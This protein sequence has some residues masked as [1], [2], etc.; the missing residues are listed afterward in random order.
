M[1]T[2]IAKQNK[3]LFPVYINGI[4]HWMSAKEYDAHLAM[5]D[6]YYHSVR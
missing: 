2:T 1:K 3:K 5:L 6:C 4:L